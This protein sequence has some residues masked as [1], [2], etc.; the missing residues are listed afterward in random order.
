LAVSRF[1]RLIRGN[2]LIAE[3]GK[4]TLETDKLALIEMATI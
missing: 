2:V 4:V 1:H 3:D